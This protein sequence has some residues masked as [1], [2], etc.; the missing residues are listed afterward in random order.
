MGP[1]RGLLEEPTPP[2]PL[3]W[4][5]QNPRPE[6]FLHYFL[7][8]SVNGLSCIVI[9]VV[10]ALSGCAGHHDAGVVGLPPNPH[11]G[12]PRALLNVSQP[13]IRGRNHRVEF[14][15]LGSPR[16]P[17]LQAS[18][19]YRF[20]LLAD[21]EIYREISWANPRV[22]R[23]FVWIIPARATREIRDDYIT[24]HV[25]VCNLAGYTYS[26]TP[27]LT[28]PFTRDAVRLRVSHP[29]AG[30]QFEQHLETPYPVL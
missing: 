10:A 11:R 4:R 2:V 12:A 7:G 22:S 30:G 28:E 17:K 23:F 29:I 20:I 1:P 24:V 9:A 21:G 16:S 13:V 27:I 19:A 15:L 18:V 8:K 26:G 14:A 6:P 25:E 5:L 3:G